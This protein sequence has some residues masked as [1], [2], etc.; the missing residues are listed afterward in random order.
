M[1]DSTGS[2]QNV[3]LQGQTY[4]RWQRTEKKEGGRGRNGMEGN[5]Q[6]ESFLTH[7]Q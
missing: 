1:D 4:R 7:M 3:Y 5:E 2:R 6:S